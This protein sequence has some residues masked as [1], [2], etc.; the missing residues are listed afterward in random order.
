M[1]CLVCRYHGQLWVPI[2]GTYTFKLYADS[3]ARLFVGTQNILNATGKVANFVSNTC[4][5]SEGKLI[6]AS[7]TY[8]LNA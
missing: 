4:L 1:C 6:C 2:A 7:C 8:I 5:C 3:S